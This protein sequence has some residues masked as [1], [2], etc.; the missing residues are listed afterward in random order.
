M[1]T[2]TIIAASSTSCHSGFLTSHANALTISLPNYL[3]PSVHIL[4]Q[5]E[6]KSGFHS[7][8]PIGDPIDTRGWTLQEELLSTR[9]IKFTENDVQWKCNAGTECMCRQPTGLQ[10]ADGNDF[11]EISSLEEKY[12]KDWHDV[13]TNFSIR[14]FSDHNDKLQA[15]AGLARV[16]QSRIRS[17]YLAGIWRS[18]IEPAASGGT[19]ALVWRVRRTGSCYDTYIA[20]SFSWASIQASIFFVYHCRE[21]LCQVHEVGTTPVT[22]SDPFGRVSDG[23]LKINGPLLRC[24]VQGRE[25]GGVEVKTQWELFHFALSEVDCPVRRIAIQD[26]DH[27]L[28][29]HPQGQTQFMET[30]A[31]VLVLCRGATSLALY[32]LLLGRDP[33]RQGYQRIGFVQFSLSTGITPSRL[34]SFCAENRQDI[35]IY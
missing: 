21:W 28:T 29:R 27:S 34:D 31:H 5:P 32:G 14:R 9:Y 22:P 2:V 4:D 6:A 10:K 16:S 20:P 15:L 11:T 7:S 13:V 25:D 26:G 12:R 18:H 17:S 24:R 23:F 8:L 35:T 1:A 30:A 3:N 19:A 33:S